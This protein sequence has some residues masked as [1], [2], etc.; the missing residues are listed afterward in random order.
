M[1]L[2]GDPHLKP[3]TGTPLHGRAS[4][5]HTG[6][7]RY[8]RNIST[9][10]DHL[11]HLTESVA[12]VFGTFVV[13]GWL[14]YNEGRV[15][16]IELLAEFHED[17]SREAE[18][19][20]YFRMFISE[21]CPA[22]D[23]PGPG[24]RTKRDLLM[25]QSCGFQR[26]LTSGTA[27]QGTRIPL[28]TWFEAVWLFCAAWPP[29]NARAF[30]AAVEVPSYSTAWGLYRK[31]LRLLDPPSHALLNGPSGIAY[32][33][34][35]GETL[36]LAIDGRPH[37]HIR[38]RWTSNPS[39]A[40][41]TDFI[42][43]WVPSGSEFYLRDEAVVDALGQGSYIDDLPVVESL[44]R[45]IN[46]SGHTGVGSKSWWRLSVP[47]LAFQREM[48]HRTTWEQFDEILERAARLVF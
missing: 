32:L 10:A 29:V 7:E 27:F 21:A 23:E 25:C 9:G 16:T 37:S 35:G 26:S 19:R 44:K 3:A 31:L 34:I 17:F 11:F 36:Y 1:I 33:D 24:W 20:A 22:C 30:Q 6:E 42:A 18:C 5:V 8:L 4:F 38:W 41:L 47:L 12:W 13:I 2:V 39:L 14:Q 43:R 28:L 40:E 45:L 46:E 48:S 15:T